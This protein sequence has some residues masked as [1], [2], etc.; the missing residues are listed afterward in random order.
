MIEVCG[1]TDI[2]VF[3][4]LFYFMESRCQ[5]T[6]PASRLADCANLVC[7]LPD[8]TPDGPFDARILI[9]PKAFC[10]IIKK[11]VIKRT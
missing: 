3:R 10:S 6:H 8:G 5:K 4:T 2:L 9:M 1:K 7:N 11:S